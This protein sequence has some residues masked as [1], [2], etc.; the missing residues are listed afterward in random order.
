MA[1]LPVLPPTLQLGFFQRLKEAEETHLLPALLKTAGELDIAL[2]DQELLAYAG[3]EKLSFIARRGMRG[4]LVFPVPCLLSAKPTLMGYYRLLLGF[5]QKEFYRS[6][7][8]R[9]QHME[10]NGVLTP[11]T[12]SLLPPLCESLI[13]SAWL[14]V[15]GLPEISQEILQS[16]TL[17]TLGPQFRG[18][19]NVTLGTEAIQTVFALIKS[20]VSE[21]VV[22]EEPTCLEVRSAAGRVYRIEFAPDP[23]IAIRQVMEGGSVRNRIAVEI[24]GG[25]DYSNIHNRLGEAE[26]SHQKA[27]AEGFTQFWTIVNVSAL[28]TTVWK[29]ET[30][31]T[32]ELFYLEQIAD[33]ESA[34]H[35]RFREYLVSELGI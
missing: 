29:Q 31:T 15:N 18:S 4:E 12:E 2:V 9:F 1:T 10:K 20:L 8:S 24:K 27:R 19:R 22:Q 35:K 33:S 28:G 5:S 3:R 21:N 16:L 7:F 26:K 14:L 32:N 13:K 11:V 23:D 30:P 25:T 6:P 34:E 17:L